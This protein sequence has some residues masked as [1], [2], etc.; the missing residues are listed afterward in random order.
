MREHP[1]EGVRIIVR[2]AASRRRSLFWWPP[3]A[4]RSVRENRTPSALPLPVAG[5]GEAAWLAGSL[6]IAIAIMVT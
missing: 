6:I 3:L 2:P 5:A 1:G 4:D